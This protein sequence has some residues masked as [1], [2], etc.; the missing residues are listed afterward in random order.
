MAV[1]SNYQVPRGQVQTNL[2]KVSIS[3]ERNYSLPTDQITLLYYR[4][5]CGPW[6][7]QF[8]FPPPPKL[9][10][11]VTRGTQDIRNGSESTSLQRSNETALIAQ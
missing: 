7:L 11:T 9:S 10:L 4:S 6:D 1:V 2:D 3:T 8:P 5:V